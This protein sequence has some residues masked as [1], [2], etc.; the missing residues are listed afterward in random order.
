MKAYK[1]YTAECDRNGKWMV[2]E[3]CYTVKSACTFCNP[4]NKEDAERWC[5]ILN[6]QFKKEK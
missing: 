2:V 4:K 1:R 3:T 6:R 5:K